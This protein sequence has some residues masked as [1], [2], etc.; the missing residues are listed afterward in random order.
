MSEEQ[1]I[2]KQIED[3]LDDKMSILC[4]APQNPKEREKVEKQFVKLRKENNS[5][6]PY[7]SKHW[8]HFKSARGTD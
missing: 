5:D 7:M 4:S 3:S 8:V 2:I 6:H 1:K